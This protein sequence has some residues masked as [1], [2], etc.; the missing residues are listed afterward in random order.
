MVALEFCKKEL[1]ERKKIVQDFRLKN[2][3]GR[4][5]SKLNAIDEWCAKYLNNIEGKRFDFK[6]VVE[7]LPQELLQIKE[8]LDRTYNVPQIMKELPRD[9]K[10]TYI[11]SCLYIGMNENAKKVLISN[12]K[13][14]VCPYCNRNYVFSDENINTCELDHFIPKSIYP[15]FASSF[16]NLIPSC[17]YCNKKKGSNEFIIYPH[18][19]TTS[20]DKLM[21]F[22]YKIL[23]SEYLTDLDDLDIELS[24]LDEA[25]QCQASILRLEDL[26]KH[27]K[28]IVQD[29]LKKRYV[30]SDAYM[31]SL[32]KEFPM[33]FETQKDIEELI[34]G[35]STKKE[36]YGK[37]PLTKM[38]QDIVNEVNENGI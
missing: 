33:L 15:I 36:E 32:C 5:L 16:Y 14:I 31:E 24:V 29:V 2:L 1:S 12:L 8:Y 4:R 11:E 23:G 18:K 27:H 3:E 6:A 20:T 38:I 13:V 10:H 25:Y 21:K 30:F 37:R 34:Y 22:S 7:A 26:Y 35:V 19:Q 9:K 17:P 28:D